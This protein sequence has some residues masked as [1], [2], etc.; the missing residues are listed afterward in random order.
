VGLTE[1]RD[2]TV[3]TVEFN[4]TLAKGKGLHYSSVEDDLI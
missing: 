1:G 2:I 3:L 4:I